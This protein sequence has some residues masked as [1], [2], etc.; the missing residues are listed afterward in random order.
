MDW[1]GLHGQLH[2]ARQK[3]F[4]GGSR[5]KGRGGRGEERGMEKGKGSR[6][7]AATIDLADA[8]FFNNSPSLHYPILF[9]VHMSCAH[10]TVSDS[11]LDESLHLEGAQS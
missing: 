6:Y 2:A 7:L 5:G 9:S 1:R 8:V 3:R 10:S 11:A 4:K